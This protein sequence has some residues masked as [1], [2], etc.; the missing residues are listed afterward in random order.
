MSDHAI[1]EAGDERTA[2][3][4]TRAPEPAA[5]TS[6]S[7]SRA[8]EGSEPPGDAHD[9][10][11]EG[12]DAGDVREAGEVGE[13]GEMGEVVGVAGDAACLHTLLQT[14]VVHRSVEEVADLVKLLRHSG[15][16]P[17]AADQALRAAAVSRPIEDVVSLAVLLS[18]E[19]EPHPQFEPQVGSEPQ[20][21]PYPVP[22]PVP[23]PVDPPGPDG[24][25][26][27]RAFRK[28]AD[29]R[30]RG[31][32][33]ADASP[34]VPGRVLRWPVAGAL[35]VA[36]LTH[37]PR[38]PSRVLADGSSATWLLLGVAGV[39][40]TLAVLVTIRDRTG[41]WLAA[42]ATGIGIV[43]LH[44]LAALLDRDP[45]GGAMGMLLP[46]PTGASMFAAGLTAFLSVMAVLYQSD[47][48]QPIPGRPI[49]G[50]PVLVT[51]DGTPV[52][53]GTPPDPATDF[54]QEAEATAT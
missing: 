43:S 38:H 41:V 26:A 39:C 4:D 6:S 8:P 42:T 46:W 30:P 27:P 20:A 3:A 36:A 49:P 50:R 47:R 32:S 48:P 9:D 44:A 13:V 18:G 22:E 11:A 25:S 51:P 5:R 21:Q 14:A 52:P 15:Q 12:G 34:R 53:P 35:L 7:P 23:A 17:D 1:P 19:D 31:T 45:L 10:V 37:L 40:L 54:V 29:R 28:R 24:R 2:A 33:D 16:V